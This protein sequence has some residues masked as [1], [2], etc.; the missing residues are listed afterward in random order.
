[1]QL[2][3]QLMNLGIYRLCIA[4]NDPLGLSLLMAKAASESEFWLD[5]F[6]ARS[7]WNGEVC[8]ELIVWDDQGFG[9]TLNLGWIDAASRRV[10][11]LRLWL[12]P[13]F[14]HLSKSA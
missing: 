10:G 11:R 2:Q 1:M 6:R 7:C 13:S 5:S 8:Q 4:N 14:S 3:A 12:R 9:D